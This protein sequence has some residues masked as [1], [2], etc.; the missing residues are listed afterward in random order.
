MAEA[1]SLAALLA[2]GVVAVETYDEGGPAPVM[3]P[4]ES[5]CVAAAVAKRRRE[6]AFGR[7]CSRAA[8]AR[9]GRG[10]PAPVVSGEHGAP[11]WPPGV[12][13]SITHVEGYYAAAVAAGSDFAAIGI[14]AAANRSLPPAVARVAAARELSDL[15]G[16]GRWP[17][18][19]FSA[20]EAVFKAWF[21]LTG[22][23][24]GFEE[25]RVILDPVA[26]MFRARLRPAGASA[27]PLVEGRF[28]VTPRL[29]LTAVCLPA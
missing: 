3:P 18:V 19:V 2:P 4:E 16:G 17:T 11:L 15:P 23:R 20:K 25:A 5:A 6:F 21:P 24:L 7:A 13:G 27:A 1:L 12:V 28:E 9:L 22:C 8:L 26:G 10:R 14:D 29:V